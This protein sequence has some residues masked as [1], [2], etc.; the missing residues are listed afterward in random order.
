MSAV[1]PP[2]TPPPTEDEVRAALEHVIDPELRA[3]IVELG[4]VDDVTI[5]RDGTVTVKVALTTAACPLRSVLKSDVERRLLALPSVADVKVVY[6]EM[7]SEQ[8]SRAMQ[9]ARFNARV[10]AAPTEV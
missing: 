6:S 4:M 2:D 9:R 10:Q 8:R 3:S 7:T 1:E 5:D